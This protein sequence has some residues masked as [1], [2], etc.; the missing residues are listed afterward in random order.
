MI[1]DLSFGVPYFV[2]IEISG[3]D[4]RITVEPFGMSYQGLIDLPDVAIFSTR[5]DCARPDCQQ[6]EWHQR[7]DFDGRNPFLHRLR[8]CSERPLLSTDYSQPFMRV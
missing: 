8:E 5:P 6:S 3:E 7:I 1:P 4:Y 2:A